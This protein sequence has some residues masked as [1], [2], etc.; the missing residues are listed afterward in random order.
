MDVG[1]GLERRTRTVIAPQWTTPVALMAILESIH[2]S[3]TTEIS[4]DDAMLLLEYRREFEL[5]NVDD[6]PLSPFDELLRFCTLTYFPVLTDSNRITQ[7]AKYV[8]LGMDSKA[9]EIMDSV[10]S[11]STAF[12]L[13]K[14]IKLLPIATFVRL[15]AKLQ[16]TPLQ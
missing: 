7:L 6:E 4:E 9:E 8:R 16:E 3:L 2:G 10:L 11:S 14:A 12:D 1:S 5:V 13:V 15:Q